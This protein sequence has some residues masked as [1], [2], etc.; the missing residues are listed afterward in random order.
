MSGIRRGTTIPCTQYGLTVQCGK[1]PSKRPYF[2]TP[3]DLLEAEN[4]EAVLN[5]K[6]EKQQAK[7][8]AEERKRALAE[9]RKTRG[10]ALAE[11]KKSMRLMQKKKI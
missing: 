4:L 7:E 1:C 2:C 11:E 3:E 10:E 8:N 9:A 5:E 6:K